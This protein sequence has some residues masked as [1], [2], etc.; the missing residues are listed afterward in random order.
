MRN[1]PGRIAFALAVPF[2][3]IAEV[4]ILT[5]AKPASQKED[6]MACLV[7]PDDGP[8]ADAKGFI[9]THSDKKGDRF[10]IRV[11]NVPTTADLQ[12]FIEDPAN[13]NV[14]GNVGPLVEAS[15]DLVIAFDTK[16]GEALPLGVTDVEALAGRRVEIRN[17]TGGV[18]LFGFVPPFGL[19]T[20]V[21][22]AK[23]KIFADETAPFPKMKGTLQLRSKPNK[24]QER[25]VFKAQHIPENS[26][27]LHVFIEDGQGVFVDDGLMEMTGKTTGRYAR[28]CT[29]GDQLPQGVT[30]VDALV[31]R[32]IELRDE[33]IA[34]ALLSAEIPELK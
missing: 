6:S 9:H 12:A 1:T 22:K 34:E 15:N 20:N 27:P 2:V 31:G 4:A 19:A 8:D 11:S 16:K 18:L 32:Q 29:D 30:S 23:V 25:I 7:R 5:A 26:G 3:L 21:S 14:F 10:D 13:S 24:G 17:A 28:D 33:T